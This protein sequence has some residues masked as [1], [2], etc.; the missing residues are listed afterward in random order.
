MARATSQ[1][2]AARR[3]ALANGH[4]RRFADNATRA[5][6]SADPATLAAWANGRDPVYRAAAQA[7]LK[8]PTSSRG[9]GFATLAANS[10]LRQKARA[11]AATAKSA[12]RQTQARDYKTYV[13]SR[14]N[15]A[16][17]TTNGNIVTAEGRR[18]G[19]KP[20]QWFTGR[21]PS[22]RYATDE[23][24]DWL[25]ANGPTLSATDFRAQSVDAVPR[26][27]NE[28]LARSSNS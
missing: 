16:D 9:G 3:A 28:F 24:K 14:R 4:T 17:A 1:Q 13:E 18:K 8:P 27:A 12:A 7:A 10:P 15:D 23:M 5:A 20:S 6:A 11:R 26:A 21:Q 25:R 19:I 22:D 2:A